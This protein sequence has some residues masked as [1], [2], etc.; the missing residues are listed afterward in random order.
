MHAPGLFLKAMPLPKLADD[1]ELFKVLEIFLEQQADPDQLQ[2]GALLGWIDETNLQTEQGFTA[3]ESVTTALMCMHAILSGAD[4]ISPF[5]IPE[6]KALSRAAQSA[7]EDVRSRSQKVLL[8]Y[9]FMPRDRPITVLIAALRQRLTLGVNTTATL[10]ALQSTLRCTDALLMC[11]S[12]ALLQLGSA[13]VLHRAAQLKQ[14]HAASLLHSEKSGASSPSFLAPQVEPLHALVQL[15][16]MH[17]ELWK[18]WQKLATMEAGTQVW[19]A[20]RTS[21][22]CHFA[23]PAP[24]SSMLSSLPRIRSS[25]LLCLS[26]TL[27]SL[28]APPPPRPA[29]VVIDSPSPGDRLRWFETPREESRTE[30]WIKREI[31][32]EAN[33]AVWT[34][35]AT[36]VRD[37]VELNLGPTFGCTSSAH[38][39][40]RS[41]QIDQWRQYM[42]DCFWP[43]WFRNM[44]LPM[45][46]PGI[47]GVN[48]AST[49]GTTACFI[50]QSRMV[51]MMEVVVEHATPQT[52]S[53][54]LSVLPTAINQQAVSVSHD[55]SVRAAQVASSH[56]SSAEPSCV[57][58]DQ[59]AQVFSF[60]EH[61]RE[62]RQLQMLLHLL[63]HQTSRII[64]NELN[65]VSALRPWLSI[66]IP[67]TTAHVVF[68]SV[69]QEI[70][71]F[72]L[73][74]LNCI[75][76]AVD[77]SVLRARSD[78]VV[79]DG[80]VNFDEVG[81]ILPLIAPFL[82]QQHV[83]PPSLSLLALRIFVAL[84]HTYSGS[85]ECFSILSVNSEEPRD[86][87]EYA[88]QQPQRIPTTVL[89][90]L[91]EQK[92]AELQKS[93]VPSPSMNDSLEGASAAIRNSSAVLPHL[94]FFGYLAELL[95]CLITCGSVS[96]H[97][98]ATFTAHH[99]DSLQRIL[100]L[101]TPIRTGQDDV[102][103]AMTLSQL[104]PGLAA[105]A[106][107][108]G[109]QVRSQIHPPGDSST[110]HYLQ[111]NGS[112]P[113]M[114]VPD[115]PL[116]R[117]TVWLEQQLSQ[118]NALTPS[119]R[120]HLTSLHSVYTSL[121]ARLNCCGYIRVEDLATGP[122]ALVVPQ[123]D[124]TLEQRVEQVRR[125]R[126]RPVKT[127]S[128]SDEWRIKLRRAI[129]YD[130]TSAAEHQLH[131]PF[132][133]PQLTTDLLSPL[134]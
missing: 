88:A 36:F 51:E 102:W 116:L 98:T 33:V 130:I 128:E 7:A 113:S 110:V 18:L 107:A 29:S 125:L 49:T 83:V 96:A 84:S 57:T 63:R 118:V 60:K 112:L 46:Q 87:L 44:E 100:S 79:V 81:S 23:I 2:P 95:R 27:W 54:L 89:Y 35:N 39:S 50:L 75:L 92:V 74:V 13:A 129:K 5:K 65:I 6:N 25:L 28:H 41:Q 73:I 68:S 121:V 64:L 21:A 16:E 101:P 31:F 55:L 103:L 82:L 77:S 12:S 34:Q 71:A 86:G 123:R 40:G 42:I 104:S 97:P 94:E 32:P 8:D 24:Y 117:L 43:D 106:T 70:H 126:E 59:A 52:G 120:S 133:F 30:R 115:H 14:H 108:A 91:L 134:H 9:V 105:V 1:G 109:C 11:L 80:D 69:V 72:Q 37:V 56:A 61:H 132:S 62:Y 3:I 127:A 114:M 124:W 47:G 53:K 119:I 17:Q 15:G 58:A 22:A 131:A 67:T 4:D 93:N 90:S 78:K 85:I 111:K 45:Q 38:S 48:E 122:S 20:D 10:A 66:A 26:H 19:V 76:A 99:A